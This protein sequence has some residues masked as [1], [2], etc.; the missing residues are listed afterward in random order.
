MMRLFIWKMNFHSKS[1]IPLALTLL[2]VY[3]LF[4]I[5]LVSFFI[6]IFA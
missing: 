3:I 6:Y 5:V 1:I 4:I 2:G